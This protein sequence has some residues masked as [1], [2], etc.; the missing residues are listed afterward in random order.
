MQITIQQYNAAIEGQKVQSELLRLQ[1][2]EKI[3]EIS[4]LTGL[5]K[6]LNAEIA[7]AYGT[8][9]EALK[10]RDAWKVAVDAALRLAQGEVPLVEPSTQAPGYELFISVLEMQRQIAELASDLE[11]AK[12]RRKRK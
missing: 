3:Q 7:R 10:S 5:L 8:T 9:A 2:Q 11:E 12:S 1:V 4:R 6:G